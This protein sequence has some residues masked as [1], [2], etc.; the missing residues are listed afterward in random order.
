MPNEQK[1]KRPKP[2]VLIILDGWGINQPYAGNAI[3]Q[4]NTP[5][6]DGLIA[7]YP[8][9]T[10]RASGEAVGLPWGEE[11]NSEVGHLNL[12]TGRI[13]YQDLP[14]INKSIS[15]NSF[16]K[17]K[18]LLKT[19]K[20]VKNNNSKLHIFGLISNGCIHSSI[21]HLHALLFLAREKRI[22]NIYIHAILDGRDTPYNS[23]LN[24]IKS[25]KSSIE[26]SGFGKIA[27][28]AG[29]FYAM[30]RDNNWDRTAQAY[31]AMAEGVGEKYEDPITAIEK[32]YKKKV[33]DEEFVPVVIVKDGQPVAKVEDN[34]AIIFFNFRPDRARQ[35]TK[36]FVLPE[37]KKFK[38]SKFIQ[39]LLFT[40]FTE[41]EKDLPVEVAF[42]SVKIKNCLG[43]I[44]SK[45]GLKQLRVAETEK[46]AHVTYFF[47]GGNEDKSEGEDHILVPSPHVSSYDQ[48]PEMS[49]LEVTKKVLEAISGNLY[50]FILINYANPDMVGHTSNI[51]AAIRAIEILDDCV[52][53]IANKVLEKGGIIMITA[54]HGNAENMFN[55][56]TGQ[57]DKE[58][59]ANPVPFILVGKQFL[60]KNLGW[61]DAAG[62]D[63]SLIQPQGILSDV[64]PTVLDIMG[65]EKP[66]EMT[67]ISLIKLPK[68]I[69]SISNKEI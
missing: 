50:D 24:F 19:V 45:F 35:I 21:D 4:A 67:G 33:Y 23:G 58:H 42:S 63:L 18:A 28:I 38:R 25:I 37:L 22:K 60:G 31:L 61:P 43:E 16:Y 47:N 68:I 11:G 1:F 49:A 12:G 6:I 32:S 53:K 40:C 65:I 57:I 2:V 39:N 17:N 26:K 62:N 54:D 36:A 13:L 3:T 56:E 14:R 7:E 66:K 30:D 41:Y 59:S 5:V 29:R 55:M 15:D 10:I 34:D 64:A 20:H 46:Y 51:P 48:K 9:T 8:A 69:N 27:T 52:G 44:L